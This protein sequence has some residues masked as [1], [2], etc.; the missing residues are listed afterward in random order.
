MKKKF[1]FAII[2]L[3][4][5][6]IIF[7]SDVGDL[8]DNAKKAYNSGDKMSA[9]QNIDAAKKII[10]QEQISSNG[11]KYIEVSNWDIVKIKK[12][13]Y[14]GK[15]IK[16]KVNFVGINSD[17]TIWLSD[18]GLNNTY[19]DSLVDTILGLTKKE[20]T[21][22]GTVLEGGILGPSMHIEAIQ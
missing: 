17:G 5:S 15:K 18:V 21:F 3:S 22:Y 16:I 9:V 19:E 12:A 1:L 20:Y 10:E 14:V 7:A 8:L 11:E 6:T 13:Q 4:V 2:L